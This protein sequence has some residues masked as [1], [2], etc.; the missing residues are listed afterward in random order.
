MT[1]KI[2]SQQDPQSPFVGNAQAGGPPADVAPP[3]GVLPEPETP[4]GPFRHNTAGATEPTPK[5]EVAQEDLPPQNDDVT[6]SA[7]SH[8]LG[9]RYVPG[10]A[11]GGPA[12]TVPNFTPAR[13]R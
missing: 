4:G 7:E 9:E 10:S 11:Q 1:K 5:Y 13:G 2:E 3:T 12:P 6:T 8:S